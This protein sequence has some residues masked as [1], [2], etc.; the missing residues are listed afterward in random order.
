[1]RIGKSEIANRRLILGI[2]CRRKRTC[3]AILLT[4]IYARWKVL[5]RRSCFV[6]SR[7]RFT[8][9]RSERGS[10]NEGA[11]IIIGIITASGAVKR[12]H[13]VHCRG[14]C[15]SALRHR[16]HET[17]HVASLPIPTGYSLSSKT[18]KK[19]KGSKAVYAVR[20]EFR[21]ER[22]RKENKEADPCLDTEIAITRRRR[23][24]RIWKL[25]EGFEGKVELPIWQR[26]RPHKSARRLPTLCVY[27]RSFLQQRCH[28]TKK[29]QFIPAVPPVIT[30]EE[31][32]GF[33]A[34]WTTLSGIPPSSLSP[35]LPFLPISR[36]E[37]QTTPTRRRSTKE[38]KYQ[39]GVRECEQISTG[40][41]GDERRTVLRKASLEEKILG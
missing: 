24:R 19:Q 5:A 40:R 13:R 15:N 29:R 18:K 28:R 22:G 38:R 16:P 39:N 11:R 14:S 34:R 12:I 4:R 3:I 9:E 1:M 41:D 2:C 8:I 37:F 17:C 32:D 7:L 10:M 6:R 36:W 26:A 25:S 31:V 30:V 21:F 20:G 27:P 35:S 33:L 23:R